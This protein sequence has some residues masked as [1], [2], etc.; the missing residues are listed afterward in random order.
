[1]CGTEL[2]FG[3]ETQKLFIMKAVWTDECILACG[4]LKIFLGKVVEI[5]ILYKEIA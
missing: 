2:N 1:M 4:F 3:N 5:P